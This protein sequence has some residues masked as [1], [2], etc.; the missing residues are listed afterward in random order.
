MEVVRHLRRN[1]K[2]LAIVN[3]YGPTEATVGCCAFEIP[4]SSK[5]EAVA[6]GFFHEGRDHLDS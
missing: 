4:S 1:A 3:H 6:V 5:S 2:E